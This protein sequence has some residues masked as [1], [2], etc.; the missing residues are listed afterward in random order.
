[1]IKIPAKK[2]QYRTPSLPFKN[3]SVIDLKMEVEALSIDKNEEKPYDIV[4]QNY[5]SS[6]KKSIFFINMQLK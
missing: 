6:E 4:T 1:V 5:C 3:M 2:G